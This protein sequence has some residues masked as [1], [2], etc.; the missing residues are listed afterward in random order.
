MK[1]LLPFLYLSVLFIGSLQAQEN[2][3]LDSLLN[4]Y[5]SLPD[6]TTKVNVLGELYNT[7]QY[8][9]VVKAKGFAQERIALSKKLNFEEGL[10]G[11]Y[12]NLGG[13]Y[14]NIFV[15]D[16]ARY[17]FTK[18][19]EI[20]KKKRDVK[21]EVMIN[22]SNAILEM[23]EGNYNK[24]LEISNANIVKRKELKDSLGLAIEY[25]FRSG[26][27]E[28]KG[29]FK[30]AYEDIL[31]ALK[32]YDVLD[33]PIRKADALNS[34]GSLESVSKN[35]EKSIDYGIEALE[36]YKEHN[37]KLFEALTSNSIGQSY[38]N[39]KKYNEAIPYLENSITLSQTLKASVL[40]GAATRNLGRAYM[41]EG[42]HKE[43]IR[44][45][46]KAVSIH[47]ESG[48]PIALIRSL[49]YAS[50]A[51]NDI[52]EPNQAI[53]HLN[54][55]I[56][57]V[58]SEGKRSHWH[59]LYEG[60]SKSWELLGDYKKSLEDH[61]K[62]QVLK[63]SV[64]N[65][66]KTQQIE[67]LR[68]IYETEKK[69]QQIAL[70]EKEITVLEQEA[71]ISNLQKV[72]LAGL[73]LIS[74]VGFY[75]IRQKLKRNRAEKEK[76]DVE[77]AYK[78]KELTT[79]ALHLAKKNEVLESLKQKAEKLKENETAKN[80]YQQLIRTINFDLQDDN[81]WK[82]FSRYFEEVHKDFNSNVKAKFPEITSNELRLLALLKMNLSSKEIANIL[83]ISPEG[84]KKARYRLRKKLNIT[85]ED[86][87]QDLVLSL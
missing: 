6:D 71:E 48:R 75:A 70:Q 14:K 51:Y 2:Q 25:V 63:D 33:E 79:H 4:V 9:D 27:Y 85:T 21:K 64:F 40:E 50:D 7:T 86:S 56:A 45:L 77:L 58:E 60:R 62:Y 73:L 82:N 52:K 18:A 29:S 43:G 3:K 15:T 81:N 68:T 8:N 41:G 69:E 59:D 1:L 61:K 54:N 31:T 84:I 39:L 12:Y 44:L 57:M 80:G 35:Y 55:A 78:K 30:L 46:E 22:Y 16:S 34:L 23:E 47:Q 83:N 10:A 13:Y 26:V 53:A 38:I 5:G 20:H 67:E 11:G 74:I 66:E 42:N 28:N 65:R 32:L 36:I 24:A 17:F 72:L 49:G 76:V 19:L 37:D 87:L